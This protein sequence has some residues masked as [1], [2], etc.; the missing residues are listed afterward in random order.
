ML[1]WEAA[2]VDGTDWLEPLEAVVDRASF[3]LDRTRPVA[4]LRA[5]DGSVRVVCWLE[6]RL[7]ARATRARLHPARNC[8]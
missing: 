4:A 6:A 5:A 7:P 8:V 2:V 3:L 1:L